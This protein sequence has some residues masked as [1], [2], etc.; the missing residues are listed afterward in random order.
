MNVILDN[1]YGIDEDELRKA[2]A[3]M[4]SENE[5]AH[6]RK[7]KDMIQDGDYKSPWERKMQQL[8]QV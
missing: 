7:I 5:E 4:K 8:Q 2:A 3:F 1:N 6:E